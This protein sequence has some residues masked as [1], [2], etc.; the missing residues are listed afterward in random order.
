MKD[1]TLLRN[2]I[3]VACFV[4][5]AYWGASFPAFFELTKTGIISLISFAFVL[6]SLTALLIGTIKMMMDK[7]GKWPFLIAIL[8]IQVAGVSMQFM[9]IYPI[10]HV[11][12]SSLF[13]LV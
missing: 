11:I 1:N 8:F 6:I 4:A 3:S 12:G 10:H 13:G 2:L 9:F 5:I 7:A